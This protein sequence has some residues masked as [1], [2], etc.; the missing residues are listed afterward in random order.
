MFGPIWPKASFPI[1]LF[2]SFHMLGAKD[3]EALEDG[4]FTRQKQRGSLS[5]CLKGSC[6]TRI[7]DSTLHEEKES[8]IILSIYVMLILRFMVYFS[9]YPSWLV[10]PG[11][12]WETQW[13]E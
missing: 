12:A 2:S 13:A 7:S 5:P 3:S 11:W 9:G 4:R 1:F 10:L 6:L 8:F